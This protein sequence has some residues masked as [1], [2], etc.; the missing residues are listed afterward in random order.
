MSPCGLLGSGESIVLEGSSSF[1]G[2]LHWWLWGMNVEK[3]GY[4]PTYLHLHFRAF[5][6]SFLAL[7]CWRAFS[8]S[9]SW[10]F[11]VWDLSARFTAVSN[12]SVLIL[13]SSALI[14]SWVGENWW[15]TG[16]THARLSKWSLISL[17]TSV[18]CIHMWSKLHSDH[19][20]GLEWSWTLR[21]CFQAS[22]FFVR[23]AIAVVVVGNNYCTWS[24]QVGLAS[25]DALA[26]LVITI[27]CCVDLEW[28]LC[29]PASCY[30][31]WALPRQKHQGK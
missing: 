10:F 17:E 23:V 24:L 25:L 13:L 9:F 29:I 27:H 3:L 16:T 30:V 21:L 14:R 6:W 20:E 31:I 19:S 28:L 7:Q 4:I 26:F 2:P 15:C 1:G 11:L 8:T 22:A 12:G 5:W 18:R